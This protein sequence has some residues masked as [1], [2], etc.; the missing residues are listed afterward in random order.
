MRCLRAELCPWG[1]I[2][3]QRRRLRGGDHQRDA[4]RKSP[5]MRLQRIVLLIIRLRRVPSRTRPAPI[6]NPSVP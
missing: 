6:Q 5:F 1:A 2:G 4:V 3:C